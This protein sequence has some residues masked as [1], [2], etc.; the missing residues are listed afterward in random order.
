MS[1]IIDEA[2]FKTTLHT[3]PRQQQR[4]L[5]ALFIQEA[6]SRLT[7]DSRIL[8]GLRTL[9]TPGA[10]DELINSAYK[11]VK[12]ASVDTFTRCGNETDWLAQA[13]HF[14]ALACAAGLTPTHQLKPSDNL[15]WNAAI[16]A[17]MANTFETIATQGNSD[18]N[19]PQRQYRVLAQFLN[20]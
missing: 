7:Q 13:I 20:N 9:Q 12:S 5:A 3:L 19:E 4:L 11:S 14:I 16:Y 15:A 2:T 8:H 1:T 18:S 10:D 6:V 17:R